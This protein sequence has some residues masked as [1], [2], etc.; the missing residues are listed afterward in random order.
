M[1]G[2]SPEDPEQQIEAVITKTLK[3]RRPTA[4][5]FVWVKMPDEILDDIANYCTT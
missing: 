1:S 2:R 3:G 4:T 5:P